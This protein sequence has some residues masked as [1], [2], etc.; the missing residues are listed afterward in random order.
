VAINVASTLLFV[1]PFVAYFSRENAVKFAAVVGASFLLA[2]VAP[3]VGWK[4]PHPYSD[5]PNNRPYPR[6]ED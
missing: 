2:F 3:P 5:D 6:K 1:L 4:R